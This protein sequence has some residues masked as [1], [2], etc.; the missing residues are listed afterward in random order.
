MSGS[1]SLCGTWGLT[2][3]EGTPLTNP[4]HYTAPV[5]EGRRLLPAQVP[6]PIHQV[7][8]AAGLLEDPNFALNS[9]RA[10]WVEEQYWI[11]RH[12][13]HAPPEALA[14]HAWLVF[15][16]LEYN[17][18]VWLNG[19]EVGRHA[20][21]LRPARF[22]VTGHLRAGENLLV[23][24]L[25]SGLH[26][27]ADRSAT[28]YAAGQI[29]LLTK[30]H[31]HRK[32]QYQS[33]WDWNP[34][35]MNVGILGDVRLEWRQA[36]R[37][38]QVSVFA[39]LSE[40]LDQAEVYGRVSLEV[41]AAEPVAAVLRMRVA[42]ADQ[43]TMLPVTLAPG[44]NRAQ[45]TL[46]LPRP[47]LWWPRGH[48][49][50]FLYTVQVSLDCGPDSETRTRRLGIRRVEI[51]RSPHPVTGEYFILK[52]NQRPIFCKG[53]NWVPPDLF[54]AS[55]PAE[56]YRK[57]V[58]MAVDANFNTLRVW[59]GGPYASP[60]LLEACD[61]LGV[62]VWHDFPFACAKYPADHPEFAAEVRREATWA[63]RERA[64]H[65]SLVVWCGNNEIEWGDWQWGY[66]ESPRTHPHYA[67]FHHDLPAIVQ[68]EDPS[69]P[70]WP[71]S[72]YSPHY[73]APN[74]PTVGD[75]HPWGVSIITP[76]PADFW[77]YRTYVDRFPN[78]GGVLGASLPATLRQ[79]LPQGE[80]YLLS[81]SWEHHDNPF[82][83]LGSSPGELGRAY[84]TVRFWTGLDP[85]ALDWEH[86]AF[87]SALLQAEGLC[88]YIANYRR[89]MFSS[90]AALFWAYNDS[91]PVTHG[92]SIV[93]YYLRRK[94][95]YHPVRRAFAPIT[96]VVAA[97][98][99]QVTVYGIN[100]TPQPWS[101]ELRFGL[102]TLAGELPFDERRDVTLPP[103]AA[104]ALAHY[105]QAQWDQLGP[106][107]SGAFAALFEG[108]RLLAQ[109]RLLRARFKDLQW[110]DPRLDFELEG[111]T[112]TVRSDG[113]AWGVCL[114]AEGD[115]PLSD[116][117][118]DVL[119]QI[120]YTLPWNADQLGA[121]RVVRL[122]NR[123]AVARG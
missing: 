66:D 25:E 112:L 28:E 64:H 1:Q 99:G 71:S 80:R 106:R 6:A 122:G 73:Q 39:L 97:E 60:V 84:Q 38:D 58:E 33:G 27:A 107:R 44:E 31:W 9:L 59:G 117:C 76:G 40:A 75:Q 93:D 45:L 78:E 13:F 52:I 81:P 50:Q 82:A 19:I 87:V 10:R 41:V 26:E 51:D 77:Q 29:E 90:A 120:P 63:V 23:V 7:L 108:G 8:M 20:N 12:T 62:L 14:Q 16:G 54:Y 72:P 47:R 65:P 102:F 69:K 3:A 113:F 104:T 68:A 85:L 74:D 2:W 43:E 123:D 22:D 46:R 15:E 89:R 5:L 109:H 24:L 4:Y 119:P 49:E 101:G 105:S 116:N 88:E 61:E 121:P 110:A 98:E 30:R 111:H 114:D 67:L 94:L 37:L 118:F 96:V 56:R 34:R 86:Y 115:L 100:D 42:E 32:P 103:N 91:W 53:A 48:G 79:F 83:C 95:A 17:A 92:W 36:V 21:A 57:L 55:V 11:Y 18:I 70:Y 35:L